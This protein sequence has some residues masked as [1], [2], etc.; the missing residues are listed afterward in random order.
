M[1]VKTKDNI[2]LKT[3]D[4]G[5]KLVVETVPNL[6]SAYCQISI[7]SGFNQENE[8]E[9]AIAHFL[10]HMLAGESSNKHSIDEI[11]QVYAKYGTEIDAYTYNDGTTYDFT[12]LQEG[13][14]SCFEILCESLYDCAFLPEEIQKE[15]LVIRQ[16]LGDVAYGLGPDQQSINILYDGQYHFPYVGHAQDI[17]NVTVQK[18][19]EF[20]NRE[21]TPN[22]TIVSIISNRPFEQIEQ[23]FMKH[24]DGRLPENNTN[25]TPNMIEMPDHNS[26][27]VIKSSAHQAI[28]SIAMAVAATDERH[29]RL[30]RAF[31]IMGLNGFDGRL[32]KRLRIDNPLVYGVSASLDKSVNSAT[33]DFECDVSKVPLCLNEVREELNS[34]A[35]HGLTEQEM[36]NIKAKNKLGTI[37]L[38]QNVEEKGDLNAIFAKKEQIYDPEQSFED[39]SKITNDDIKSFAKE[40]CEANFAVAAEGYKIKHS[41]LHFFDDDFR[42]A[43]KHLMEEQPKRKFSIFKNQGQER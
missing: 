6:K 7:G 4:N 12:C 16:E 5:L 24:M 1:D 17:E 36:T 25:K 38:L 43:N 19:K 2:T 9:R 41:A 27:M 23:M 39:V 10:E 18:L 21:Y 28:V 3:Y 42:I 26:V 22:N 13:L 37:G 32:Y 29:K 33:I 40:L 8:D 15:K 35:E 14:E 30:A 11:N 34:L 31:T 20:Y